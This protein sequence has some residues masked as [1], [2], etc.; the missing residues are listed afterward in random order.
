MALPALRRA[1]EI[2][3][4]K[5]PD[6]VENYRHTVLRAG[7]DVARA[8]DGVSEAESAML[9]KIRDALTGS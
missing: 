2:L 9:D 8:V 4:A 5:A 1:V 7:D 6:E 3:R